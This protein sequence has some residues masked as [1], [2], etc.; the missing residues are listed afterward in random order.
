MSVDK[1]AINFPLLSFTRASLEIVND[2]RYMHVLRAARIN[3]PLA[4]LQIETKSAF[5]MNMVD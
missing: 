3:T 2:L 5:V 1:C 4:I